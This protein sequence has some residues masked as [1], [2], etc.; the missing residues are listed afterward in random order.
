M[1]IFGLNIS[2][3]P[4]TKSAPETPV[5]QLSAEALAWL[6]G[7]DIAP[8]SPVMHDAYQQVV[9]VYRAINVLAEQVA[10]IPFLFS[11]GERGR[12]SLIT[13]GPL[14]DFYERPHPHFNRFQYWEMR[15]LWLM[16]RG[17]CMRVPIYEDRV[18]REPDRPFSAKYS[19]QTLEPIEP[20]PPV[21]AQVE[22][23]HKSRTA[24]LKS[25]LMLDP[26]DFQHVVENHKLVGWRYRRPRTN[27][28]LDVDMLLPE[29]VWFDRL[30]NPYDYWRGMAPLLVAD[31]AAKTDFAAST[32]MRE[33]IDNNA[34][35]GLIVRTEQQLSAE[36]REQIT[37]EIRRRRSSRTASG[38]SVLLWGANEVIQPRI[39]SA[40]LQFLQNRK[41]TRSE[42]CAAFGVPEEILTSTDHSKYDVMQGARL[43]FIENRVAPLCARLEAEEQ[44]IIKTI[45]PNAVGWFDIDSLP[46]MQEARRNRVAVAKLGFELGIPFNE[47]NRLFDLGFK[48]LP[49]GDIGYVPRSMLPVGK[50]AQKYFPSNG[51]QKALESIKIP[52][53]DIEKAVSAP[54]SSNVTRPQNDFSNLTQAQREKLAL[55]LRQLNSAIR[56]IFSPT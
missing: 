54:G 22:S 2:R 27:S 46:I 30:P 11:K 20:P 55:T 24:K 41:F 48:P 3:A 15:V 42:I 26:A 43:N 5:P 6:S 4:R 53:T 47:L 40:D 13:S 35:N 45:D 34:E 1:N 23:I 50:S 9:W 52:G 33:I 29:E 25:I 31:L 38:R 7:H 8:P 14:I 12:E 37:A 16:L 21:Y 32:F 36:Q 51:D 17:E 19:L 49:W 56:S 39:S 28:P 10:N 18:Q 44:A